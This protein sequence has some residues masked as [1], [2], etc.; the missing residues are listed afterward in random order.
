MDIQPQI[1]F[2]DKVDYFM[3]PFM[4]EL[5]RELINKRDAL[6]SI[7]FHA[8][9]ANTDR[10]LKEYLRDFI[11]KS[12]NKLPQ[13]DKSFYI[14]YI[15]SEKQ[16]IVFNYS[17]F[18]EIYIS[19]VYLPEEITE[20][21]KEQVRKQD[22]VY[23]NPDILLEVTNGKDINY[24][25]VELKST[26]TNAIPGSSVQQVTPTEWVI[27]VKHTNT[28]VSITTGQYIN[29]INSTMQFPDRSPRPSVAFNELQN[30]NKL[31]RN[32]TKDD[33]TGKDLLTVTI[34]EDLLKHKVELLE[35]WQGILVKR[36]LEV[37]KR[38]SVKK[39]EAWFNNTIRRFTLDFLTMYEELSDAEKDNLKRTIHNAIDLY[40]KKCKSDN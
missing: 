8:D 2:N 11:Q 30:W 18:K 39:T 4:N 1:P 23:T 19:K 25:P 31:F 9:E 5:E 15:H 16:S 40:N 7:A 21:I 20:T 13:L 26:K 38:N 29:S 24:M 12:F 28:D 27:F 14:N 17:F 10:E 37:I 32:D 35:D 6:K 34:S 36:W 33:L 3:Y 22:S